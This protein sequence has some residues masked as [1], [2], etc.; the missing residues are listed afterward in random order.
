MADIEA[1]SLPLL[2][3]LTRSEYP[4]ARELFDLVLEEL[5]LPP[6]A[7]DVR[8]Q[9]DAIDALGRALRNFENDFRTSPPALDRL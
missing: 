5:G 3:G 7:S 1:P 6:P 9:R 8:L 4:S 2:T